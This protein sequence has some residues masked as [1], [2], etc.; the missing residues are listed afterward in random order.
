MRGRNYCC[1]QCGATLTID[2]EYSG[3]TAV[4][5]ASCPECSMSFPSVDLDDIQT[6]TDIGKAPHV[7]VLNAARMLGRPREDGWVMQ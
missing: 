2:C 4:T 6:N 3:N 1:T 7:T 5:T